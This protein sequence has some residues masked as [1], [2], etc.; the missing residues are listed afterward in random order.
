[1]AEHTMKVQINE[2]DLKKKME[3]ALNEIREHGNRC[4]EVE[5]DGTVR[6]LDHGEPV[7]GGTYGFAWIPP[8]IGHFCGLTIEHSRAEPEPL[9]NLGM[10]TTRDLLNELRARGN[11]ND[12]SLAANQALKIMKASAEML[13]NTLPSRLLE[14]RTWDG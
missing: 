6:V 3:K 7:L 2:K 10:A 4:L 1:M 14:Y 13:L 5:R 8:A 12:P 9:A 11:H